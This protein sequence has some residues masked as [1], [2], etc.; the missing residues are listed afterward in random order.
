MTDASTAGTSV[1]AVFDRLASHGQVPSLR[2]TSGTYEFDLD[3]GGGHWFLKLDHGTPSVQS[4]V[5][6]PT[7]TVH[8]HRSDFVAIAE[9]KTNMV[10]AYLRGDLTLAGN[11]AF[12]LTFRHMLPVA[13]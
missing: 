1:P 10:T 2:R 9:G 8:M 13:A 11:L 6:H 7:C 12:A 3:D 4:N 5:E